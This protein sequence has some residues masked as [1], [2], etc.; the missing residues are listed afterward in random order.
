MSSLNPFFYFLSL[1]LPDSR[2]RKNAACKSP[3]EI[4]KGSYSPS[5]DDIL[6]VKDCLSVKFPIEVV[7][8]IIDFAEYWSH[9]QVALKKDAAH[10]S[11]KIIG[12]AN[13]NEF[14]LRSYPLAFI[15]KDHDLADLSFQG[16]SFPTSSPNPGPEGDD[17]SHELTKLYVQRWAEESRVR[18]SHPCRKIVFTIESHDQ[19][20]GGIPNSRGTYEDSFTWFDVGKEEACIYDVGKCS[21]SQPS[22]P[23]L[24]EVPDDNFRDPFFIVPSLS[25][26]APRNNSSECTGTNTIYCTSRTIIPRI[27]SD[28]P[29]STPNNSRRPSQFEHPLL[30][31]SKVLQKNI[32]A[33]KETKKHVITWSYNDNID[34]DSHAGTLLE[35]Q[36]RGRAT[37]NGEFVRNLRIG[38]TVTVWGKSRFPGWS[39]SVEGLSIDVYWAV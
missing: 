25:T 12:G 20:W 7:D 15:P 34:P 22:S 14:L 9:V 36:G 16:R 17:Y 2:K 33:E 10:G 23:R 3:E 18:G 38:E 32:T 31:D 6:D 11:Y 29:D 30:P 28:T 24:P 5:V 1:V 19:G 39:N 13:E 27:V 26:F 4:M 37:A 35:K 21:S 8:A